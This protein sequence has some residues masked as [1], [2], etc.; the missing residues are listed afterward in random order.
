MSWRLTGFAG[1]SGAYAF[2]VGLGPRCVEVCLGRPS[3]GRRAQAHHVQEWVLIGRI[4]VRPPRS[5]GA[6][7]RA[8]CVL[9]VGA[10]RN[11]TVGARSN[12][13]LELGEGSRHMGRC[14]SLDRPLD[15]WQRGLDN[16][17]REGV[18]VMRFALSGGEATS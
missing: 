11:K 17:I 2:F 14:L 13:P 18:W 12:A 15:F 9:R 3:S 1:K 5:A 6:S 7:Y 10:V 8:G 4:A 16:G